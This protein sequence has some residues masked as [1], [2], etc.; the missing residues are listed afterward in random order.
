MSRAGNLL[1]RAGEDVRAVLRHSGPV[2]P[3]TIV[4]LWHRACSTF[5]ITPVLHENAT[6]PI[7]PLTVPLPP[8]PPALI[9]T[10]ASWDKRDGKAVLGIAYR[11]DAG[12]VRSH[13]ILVTDRLESPYEAEAVCLALQSLQLLWKDTPTVT[14]SLSNVARMRSVCANPQLVRALSLRLAAYLHYTL[15]LGDD[16]PISWVP[17]HTTP[18]SE[19]DSEEKV[20]N[21]AADDATN[22][23]APTLS[24]S[25]ADV[26]T[27]LPFSPMIDGREWVYRRRHRHPVF[28]FHTRFGEGMPLKFCDLG[29][30]SWYWETRFSPPR[31]LLPHIVLHRLLAVRTRALFPRH[32]RPGSNP[33]V[34]GADATLWH[35][36]VSCTWAAHVRNWVPFLASL[37]LRLGSGWWSSLCRGACVCGLDGYTCRHALM[38]LL[39]APAYGDTGLVPPHFLL[40]LREMATYLSDRIGVCCP[41][42]RGVVDAV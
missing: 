41:S 16:F 35:V 13:S 22:D 5:A 12:V 25:L 10:D 11:D 40:A 36:A 6:P 3:L 7:W 14:D 4:T 42:R 33:C 24:I 37:E 27:P 17:G 21:R 1:T 18:G 30:V 23:P 26:T 15:L 34:C 9:A 31:S 20:L 19:D 8:A 32:Q 29:N 28:E 38:C 39:P 2:A